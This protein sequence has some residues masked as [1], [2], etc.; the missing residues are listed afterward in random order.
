[1]NVW[2]V[3]DIES[4]KEGNKRRSKIV[5]EIKKFGLYRV[6]KS[7]FAGNI[8]NNRFDELYIFSKN[9][10]DQQ[11]DSVYIFPM[12]KADFEAVKLIGKGFD[13]DLISGEK[14]EIFL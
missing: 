12:C 8:E 14:K 9:M 4:S 3:Y 6:Q 11:K 7:V 5:K 2:V 13:K 1:M 10:I